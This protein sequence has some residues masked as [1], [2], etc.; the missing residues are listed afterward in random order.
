M[1]FVVGIFRYTI[2]SS[3]SLSISLRVYWL[4]GY[5]G[6]VFV[7][8]FLVHTLLPSKQC[9]RQLLNIFSTDFISIYANIEK[10]IYRK[11]KPTK[12]CLLNDAHITNQI[13]TEGQ[14]L[15][16]R[17]CEYTDTTTLICYRLFDRFFF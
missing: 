9:N 13:T 14:N 2:R 4:N 10:N 3:L 5:F 1:F 15:S 6:F 11:R 16:S 12:I 17:I 7:I 8:W